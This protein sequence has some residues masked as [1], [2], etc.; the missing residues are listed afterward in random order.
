MNSARPMLNASILADRVR[1]YDTYS[2]PAHSNRP[3]APMVAKPKPVQQ[4][5]LPQPVQ[6]SRIAAVNS[7]SQ[8]VFKER[9][10]VQ[11]SH[12]SPTERVLL[13]A[14]SHAV[15]SHDDVLAEQFSTMPLT[16]PVRRTTLFQRL[17]Y[18][19]GVAVFIFASFASAQTFFVNNEAKEQ[20]QVLGEQ[21][22]KPDEYGVVEGTGSE[23]A[24][25][26][27]S[28]SAVASYKVNPE[29]PRYIR[30]PE[31]NVFARI[32]HTGIDKSGAV[33]APAN[34]NDVSWFNQS[35]K[36]GNANGSSLLLGHVSGWSAPG[37]FKK[38]NQLK[39][40]MRF[41]IEKGSGE[42]LTYEVVRGE[43]IPLEQVNMSSILA[44]EVPGEHDLKL[45]TCSGRY[46]K[47]KD[48]YEERY[49]VYAKILR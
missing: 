13:S 32:K 27:V 33:D 44:S 43:S 34:V 25:A 30:I 6:T 46:N 45:M 8:S 47:E 39:P 11:K 23:P 28:Q 14:V 1:K 35:A 36:P 15:A 38:I 24:E 5:I 19:V 18:G 20:L 42:K 29:L 3:I 37:V 9:A 10:I 16:A 26:E 21:T 2:P 41:E 12:E 49:V 40:G 7:T 4:R 48:H 31:L 22:Q 17:F